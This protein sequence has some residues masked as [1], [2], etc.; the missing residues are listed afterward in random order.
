MSLKWILSFS[1]N[2]DR[3]PLLTAIVG[4]VKRKR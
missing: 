2:P 3:A 1:L 4:Q